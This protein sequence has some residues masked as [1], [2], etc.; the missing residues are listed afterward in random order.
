MFARSIAGA[1]LSWWISF[2][3]VV[4]LLILLDAA[5][6]IASTPRRKTG[7]ALLSSLFLAFCA[8]V[9]A[10]WLNARQGR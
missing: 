10:F 2:H 5:L 8:L 9:F 3:A 4:L 7:L 1:P 6:P